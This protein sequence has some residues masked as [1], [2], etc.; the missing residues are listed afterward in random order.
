MMIHP[1][2]KYI[3]QMPLIV[4]EGGDGIG[5][6]T[7]CNLLAQILG[8]KEI[9]N[10]VSPLQVSRYYIN[11]IH[12][13]LQDRSTQTGRLINTFLERDNNEDEKDTDPNTVMLL[14]AA[15]LFEQKYNDIQFYCSFLYVQLSVDQGLRML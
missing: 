14:F 5:K 12:T 1:R 8:T 11:Y 4:L 7:Q 3:L 2:T 9:S 10:Q 15:N 6:T 13:S